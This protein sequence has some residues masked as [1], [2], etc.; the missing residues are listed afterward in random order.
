MI[1]SIVLAESI[2]ITRISL[3]ELGSYM[4][5]RGAL[6]LFGTVA[7]AV[8][9]T[10]A[11]AQE[12]QRDP[13]QSAGASS[14]QAAI[15]QEQ[16][17]K[18]AESH[19][20]VPNKAERIFERID[21]IVAGGV[22]RWH[23]Y[24]ESA[25]SGGGF[26]LG[27]GHTQYVSAYNY[28]DARGSYTFSGYKRAEVEFTAPRLFDR[29]ARLSALGGWREATQVGFYGLGMDTAGRRPHQLPVPA[30]V[31][32]AHFHPL[33]D[34]PNSDAARRPGVA[35]WSQ[36]P[37]EGSSPSVETGLHARGTCRDLVPR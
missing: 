9:S 18:L 21:T 5:I 19:P 36:E 16:A 33:P 15:E 34:S 23:P 26:T 24:F 8:A 29:R 30:A 35:H 17:A 1:V 13:P 10:R 25:Y 31:P 28:I 6:T 14:R 37:G 32:A 2:I 11:A 3:K 4:C 20:Y 7:L 27:V 12:P 22:P